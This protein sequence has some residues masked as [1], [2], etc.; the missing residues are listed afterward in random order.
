MKERAFN[1]LD[2]DWIVVLLEDGSTEKVSIVGALDRAGACRSLAGEL[3]TQDAAILRLLL[4]ILHTVIARY[5]ASGADAPIES[6]AQAL[7]RW[8]RIWDAGRFPMEAIR[9]YLGRY[10]DRFWLF[11]AE[12]PFYQVPEI[13]K[14]TDYT[15]AK[16]NGELSESNNKIR[17]FPQRSGRAKNALAYDE[18]ARWLLYVNAFDDTSGKKSAKADL[19][20]PGAGWLGKLGVVMAEGDN[21][22]ETLML[23]LVLLADGGNELWGEEQPI[24]ERDEVKRAERT[25]IPLPDNLAQLYTLQSRR[26]ELKRA[27]DRVIGYVLLGGDFFSKDNA[28]AEQMTAWRN[29]AKNERSAPLYQ[30]RRHDPSRQMWRD[31]AS[32]IA[33]AEGRRPGVVNW[34]ARLMRDGALQRSAI[35]LKTASAKYADKD[36]FI[37]DVF[38]DAMAFSASMLDEK[39]E[40]WVGVVTDQIGI[41]EK[42]VQQLAD[43]AQRVAKAAGD[44]DGVNARAAA[45]QEAYFA[46]DVPF[47]QWLE[48]IDTEHDEQGEVAKRWWEAAQGT[49]RALGRDL[50]ASAGPQALVGRTI[51]ENKKARTYCAPDAYNYFL[52]RTSSVQALTT[53]GKGNG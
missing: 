48:G 15:A 10:H 21:L 34:L 28:F 47:R 25:E 23:N 13:G 12:R 19:P 24:W 9:A 36:F 5:D 7:R 44:A 8:K 46:L 32:L 41:S 26:I 35:R 20:S 6:P 43:L 37:D 4:A 16:L 33:R 17:L 50:I 29:N 11:D 49:I 3:P 14:G 30:P 2:E 38:G 51:S 42:L 22:F 52:Y 27:E 1:L 40:Q 39:G 53:G 18:A 45:R 31:F